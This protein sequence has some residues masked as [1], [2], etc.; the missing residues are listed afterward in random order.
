LLV[1]VPVLRVFDSQQIRPLGGEESDKSE[2]IAVSGV[3]A[4]SDAA[5]VL[6]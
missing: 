3:D 6:E 2:I 4:A 1:Q 5:L